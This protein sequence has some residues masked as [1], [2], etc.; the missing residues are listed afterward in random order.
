MS[1]PNWLKDLFIDEAKGSL[2]GRGNGSG[3]SGGNLTK[4]SQ[5]ENDLFYY[6]RE[7]FLK[8][9]PSD[10][11]NVE[12]MFVYDSGQPALDWLTGADKLG[13][14]FVLDV[15]GETIVV[16]E[17]D[18]PVVDG[19]ALGVPAEIASTI[20]EC[21]EFI[22]SNGFPELGSNFMA[23]LP[24]EVYS[25][26]ESIELF[27]TNIKKIPKDVLDIDLTAI[28]ETSN[29]AKTAANEALTIANQ[30]KIPIFTATSD[31][32]NMYYI[33]DPGFIPVHGELCVIVPEVRS[34]SRL[35]GLRINDTYC[36]FNRTYTNNVRSFADI[37]TD[38]FLHEGTPLLI[39]FVIEGENLIAV[40]IGY[41][42]PSVTNG[43]KVCSSLA[44]ATDKI[45]YI[46]NFIS[47]P[48]ATATVVFENGNTAVAP[49]LHIEGGN[50]LPI[51]DRT[52]AAIAADAIKTGYA[53]SFVSDGSH[54]ILLD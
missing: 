9:T 17:D 28:E 19:F 23:C 2:N 12:S 36:S 11:T 3:G 1:N 51:V 25:H 40:V 54:W 15:N 5:L 48:G 8:L 4:L 30:A 7:S 46:P 33:N 24:S 35:I 18:F 13:Y 50:S 16:T 52:G 42:E 39:Q 41:N 37:P 20:F 29:A 45:A 32:G 31:N 44:G 10:F 6:S 43:Y 38:N 26:M 22:I 21:G 27:N 49:S 47:N 53:H 34:T 14:R